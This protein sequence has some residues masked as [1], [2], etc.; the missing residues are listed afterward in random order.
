MRTITYEEHDELVA[1]LR[2]RTDLIKYVPDGGS[3][4]SEER[5]EF[6]AG[7]LAAF[8]DGRWADAVTKIERRYEPRGRAPWA[9]EAAERERRAKKGRAA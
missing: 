3:M 7:V 4:L 2:H 9:I 1:A 6:W 8:R 5:G